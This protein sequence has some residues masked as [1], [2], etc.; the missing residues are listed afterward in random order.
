MDSMTAEILSV[1]L[2]TLL[3]Q[4]LIGEDCY[5]AAQNR[6]SILWGDEG[7]TALAVHKPSQEWTEGSEPLW[8]YGSFDPN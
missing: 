2:K 8:I 5:H 4:N 6:I 3:D 7:P 1:L